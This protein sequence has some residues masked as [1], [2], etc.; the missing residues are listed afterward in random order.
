M[1]RTVRR[2]HYA[3]RGESDA[4]GMNYLL[5]AFVFFWDRRN[6]GKEKPRRPKLTGLV[7]QTP[8]DGARR[9]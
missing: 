7:S 5:T 1:R 8:G 9:D 2:M 6:S 4:A 3:R